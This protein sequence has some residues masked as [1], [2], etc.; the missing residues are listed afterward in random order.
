M[1]F[2]HKFYLLNIKRSKKYKDLTK[3]EK[4]QAILKLYDDFIKRHL[5]PINKTNNYQLIKLSYYFLEKFQWYLL[6]IQEMEFK[7]IS[8]NQFFKIKGK[9]SRAEFFNF[10]K[11]LILLIN[12]SNFE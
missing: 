8:I 11:L 2:K 6:V 1:Y 12:K 9:Y 10:K 5:K 3:N 7:H 4:Y